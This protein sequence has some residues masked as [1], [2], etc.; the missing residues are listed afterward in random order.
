MAKPR[1]CVVPCCQGERFEL[2]HKFPSDRERAE[3]WKLILGIQELEH[4]DVDAIRGKHFVCSRHFRDSDYKNKLS[5]SLNVTANPSLNLNGLWHPEGLNRVIPPMARPGI[6]AERM[7]QEQKNEEPMGNV[8]TVS[9]EVQPGHD[10]QVLDQE[11]N[12][13]CIYN[14]D[15]VEDSVQQQSSVQ[16]IDII[17][18]PTPTPKPLPA[19]QA[20]KRTLSVKSLAGSTPAKIFKVRNN[21]ESDD[22]TVLKGQARQELILRKI[23]LA[24]SPQKPSFRLTPPTRTVPATVST[25]TQTD[26]ETESSSVE[27]LEQPSDAQLQ[28]LDV[29][30]E[31]KTTKMTK[32]LAL[33]EC[34]PENLAKLQRKM[35]CADG[36]AIPFDEKLFQ[37]I[38]QG[39][40]DK[41]EMKQTTVDE[42]Y[43]LTLVRPGQEE[44]VPVSY[45]WLR[46][47][48]R[49]N[50]CYNHETFQRTLSVLDIPDDVAP[51]SYE[52]RDG[53]L[54]VI[55]KDGHRSAYELSFVFDNLFESHREATLQEQLRPVLWDR[56]FIS[57]CPDYCRV[58]LNEL[59]CDDEVVDKLVSSLVTY[60]VAFIEKVP[61]NT[62]STEMAIKRI[63]PIHKTFFGEMWTFT[64]NLD[65]SDTS[66]TKAYLGPHTDNTYF[67]EAAAIQVLHCIQFNGTGGETIL[68]D[69]FKA[70]EQ[71]KLKNPEAY[72]RLT[73]VPLSCEYIEHGQ[74]HVDTTPV[75]KTNILT[76]ELEQI[77]VNTYDRSIMKTIPQQQM[78]QFYADYKGLVAEINDPANAWQFSLRPGTVMLFNNWRLLHGRMAYTGK[79]VMTGCYVARTDFQS[80]ARTLG[81]IS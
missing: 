34:T 40:E 42:R 46:D 57:D 49:C 3:Q 53:S 44:P 81:I 59:L 24:T 8:V 43:F 61:A 73:K 63:F 35:G 16:Q 1:P 64:D 50:E 20:Q 27:R 7:S 19:G 48:C 14:T 21:A 5:R 32:V 52:V 51:E 78:P 31:D 67:S 54:N 60:G 76:G 79:R 28:V 12:M 62:Q 18:I 30:A 66:Y 72:E 45:I 11:S 25:E 22:V 71:Y 10:M 23:K 4:L 41:A 13:M 39:E 56:E 70:A 2:V 37:E 47:H 77:R 33:L 75:L 55:W 36:G 26:A 69:G 17:E 15:S 58:K 6:S 9:L 29:S 80:V 68:I 65:H 74:Y 38:A